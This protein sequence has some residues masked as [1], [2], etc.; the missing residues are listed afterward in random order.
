MVDQ[1]G[2][3]DRDVRKNLYYQ[4]RREELRNDDL[5]VIGYLKSNSPCPSGNFSNWVVWRISSYAGASVELVQSACTREPYGRLARSHTGRYLQY[6]NNR[7]SIRHA[8]YDK[9]LI[10]RKWSSQKV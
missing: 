7:L 5:D 3:F 8:C 10:H 4:W 6:D 9:C 1:D 2:L